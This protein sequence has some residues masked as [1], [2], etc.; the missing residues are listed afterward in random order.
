MPFS[1][2]CVILD[3]G[4]GPS[5]AT[6]WKCWLALL[7]EICLT[8]T[9]GEPAILLQIALHMQLLIVC[10]LQL[11]LKCWG[12]PCSCT[13]QDMMPSSQISITRVSLK[14]TQWSSTL[15]ASYDICYSFLCTVT[16][17]CWPSLTPLFSLVTIFCGT[18]QVTT[19][20]ADRIT[21]ICWMPNM[22]DG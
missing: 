12:Q 22:A 3:I 11:N 8:F 5:R 17:S 7:W 13:L 16:T 18:R 6:P 1:L 20:K 9:R 4:C 19:A 2:K 15:A 21:Y 10:Y 14:L